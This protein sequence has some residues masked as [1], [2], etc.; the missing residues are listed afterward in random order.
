MSKKVVL[1]L[2][3]GVLAAI[4]SLI[5]W[6]TANSLGFTIAIVLAVL[7]IVLTLVEVL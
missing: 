2:C 3:L 6:T 4:V 7:F 5:L 1:F